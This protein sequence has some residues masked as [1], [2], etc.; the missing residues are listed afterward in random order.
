MRFVRDVEEI[1]VL[2][3]EPRQEGRTL[4][5]IVAPKKEK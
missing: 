1:A 4:F 5:I 3:R 2:E